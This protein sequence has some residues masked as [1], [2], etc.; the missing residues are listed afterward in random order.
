MEGKIPKYNT[1]ML[2]MITFSWHHKTGLGT[3]TDHVVKHQNKMFQSDDSAI[4][5]RR[6]FQQFFL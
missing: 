4:E 1:N 6:N 3:G 2:I 5:I